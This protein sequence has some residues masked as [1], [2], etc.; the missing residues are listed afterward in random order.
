MRTSTERVLAACQFRKPDRL[1]RFDRFWSFPEAWRRRL[2]D[3]DELTG[4][5]GQSASDGDHPKAHN[6]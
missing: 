6:T 5:M 1:P 3:P 4:G 2:G